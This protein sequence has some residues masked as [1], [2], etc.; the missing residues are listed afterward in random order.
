MG[1]V[2]DVWRRRRA[3]V[4]DHGHGAGIEPLKAGM[5]HV[6]HRCAVGIV[7]GEQ[8]RQQVG[9]RA[10]HA[11]EQRKAAVAVAEEAQHRH[12]AVD[13]VQQRRRRRDVAGGEGLPQ[14]QQVDQKFDQRSRIARDVPA[15]GQDLPLQLVGELAGG[16]ADVAAPGWQGRA[17]RSTARSGS[18]AAARRREY[19]ASCSA[20]SGSHASARADSV[21]RICRRYRRAPKAPATTARFT[22]RGQHVGAP[23]DRA[24]LRRVRNPVVDQG[25]GIGGGV[26]AVCRRRANAAAIQSRAAPLPSLPTAARDRR[27]SGRGR[28][29]SCRRT[30]SGRHRFRRHGWRRRSRKVMR[31]DDQAVGA[32]RPQ[33][34][35]RHRAAARTRHQVPR[36]AA[37]D[38]RRDSSALSDRHALP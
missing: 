6:R 22:R 37:H 1:V 36:E 31:G 17:R 38:Q 23:P 12:Q 33:P 26:S 7:I 21:D 11:V 16:G 19:R 3:G 10:A 35:Q 29:R 30:Q 2:A 34:R 15:I 18:A 9:R 28:S 25:A 27:S 5:R 24:F 20:D 8:G 13:R 32:A 14:R 4:H